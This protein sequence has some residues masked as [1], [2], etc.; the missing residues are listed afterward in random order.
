MAN[1]PYTSVSISGYN[2][3]PP[4]DDGSQTSANQLE[5]AKHKT[6]L[7][8]PVKTGV[9]SVNSNTNSA[10]GALVMTDDPGQ[11]TVVVMA[12]MFDA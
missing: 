3:S 7:G 9:E 8:D 12:A 5:W 10:F 11:E 1:N 6:K 4:P 2:T